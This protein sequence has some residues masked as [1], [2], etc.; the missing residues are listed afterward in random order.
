[1]EVTALDLREFICAEVDLSFAVINEH[2]VS[3]FSPNKSF[4]IESEFNILVDGGTI[5]L[6]FTYEFDRM[7]HVYIV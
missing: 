4:C 2:G 7:I 6:V 3:G 1:M 5:W